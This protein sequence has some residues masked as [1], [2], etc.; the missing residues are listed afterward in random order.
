MTWRRLHLVRALAASGLVSSL[1]IL[2]SPLSTAQAVDASDPSTLPS[3]A[4]TETVDLLR[5]SKAGDLSVA[6]RG[7][8]QDQVRLTIHNT[9]TK[10]LN[11]IVPPGLVAASAAGQGG[12]G[13][14]QSMGLGMIT[15]RP[16][17]FGQFVGGRD[18]I[19]LRSVPVVGAPSGVSLAVPVGETINVSVPAVCLNYGVD[20]P[21]PRDSFT[22]MDVDEYST[23]VRVRK[24]LR[25]LALLGTSQGVAQATMW[26]LCNGVA[27]QTMAA[28]EG[29]VI[30]T[31]EI[32]LAAR[33][34]D[35]VDASN[36]DLVDPSLL[37]EG[38]IHVQV[39]AE[40]PF[41][42]DARRLNEKL[43]G[44]RLLGLPIESVDGDEPPST[45][46]PAL[47]VKITVTSSEIGA[48][49]G[50]VNVNYCSADDRW[51]PLGKTTFNDHASLA[52]L[53]AESLVQN[54]ETELVQT[55]VTVEAVKRTVTSTTL[56][57]E[58]HL[59]FTLSAVRLRAGTSPGSPR[60]PFAA[61][62][63]GPA[64]SALLPIQAGKAVV[65]TVDLN[66]L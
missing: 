14:F 1:V 29:K 65:E 53:D 45:Q 25:S 22:L 17:S 66:G 15:N 12:R 31:H 8:G 58:N 23:D 57:V 11:V 55:F 54:L 50:R 16:G 35:A 52:V 62:G 28:H 56:R 63:I 21:K 18:T 2:G 13:G 48:T 43:N 36:G 5:A 6:A 64:R 40:G 4:E 38:R 49:R 39:V 19:G 37:T 3:G 33:F 46:A 9:S 26:R 32:A 34:V 7:Q 42:A 24:G 20:A 61:V 47:F 51:R 27:F 41:S 30:N 10:R 59:P 44:L 60:V